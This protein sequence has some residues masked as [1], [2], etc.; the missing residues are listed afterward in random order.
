MGLMK[1]RNVED[2]YSRILDDMGFDLST[3]IEEE[4]KVKIKTKN[5]KTK[6]NKIP[7][8]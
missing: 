3:D 6:M 8:D 4:K 1:D 5:K 7:K 2:E